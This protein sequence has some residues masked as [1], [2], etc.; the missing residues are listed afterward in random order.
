MEQVK[1]VFGGKRVQYLWTDTQ[2]DSGKVPELLS[3]G[4][5]GSLNYFYGVFLPYFLWPVIM[6]CLVHG[7]Y[8]LYLKILPCGRTHLLAKMDP[9][10]KASG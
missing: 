5:S 6:I 8:S 3:H 9:T 2:A 1:Y 10:E 7:P 4:P